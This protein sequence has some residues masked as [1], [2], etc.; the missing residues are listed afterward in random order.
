MEFAPEGPMAIPLWIN[1]RAYL[2]V[3]DSFFD[4]VNPSTGESLRRVPMC[5]SEEAAEALTA[6]RAAQPGWAAMGMNARRVCL[7]SLADAL[8]KYSGH[9]AKLLVQDLGV[10]EE[11]AAREVDA[12]IAALRGVSVGH[13]GVLAV[14]VDASQ[15]LVGLAGAMAPALLAGA[16]VVMKPSLKA[17]SAAY[18]LCE[19]SGRVEWPAGVLNLLHGDAPAISGLCSGGVDRLVY[20]GESALGAQVAAIAGE[21]SVPFE[22]FAA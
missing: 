15:S 6:A 18:A 11:N 7:N 4:V 8:A 21:A 20:A 3:G 19:L 14:V 9:F 1:G 10:E 13:G 16:S 12:A 17:P 5:G 2:T 22:Q